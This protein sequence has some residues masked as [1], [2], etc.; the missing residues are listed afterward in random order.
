MK[1]LFENLIFFLALLCFFACKPSFSN[2]A[3]TAEKRSFASLYADAPPIMTGAAQMH[4]YIPFIK[5]KK[6]A[7]LANHTSLVGNTHLVDTL[8]ASGVSIQKIFSPEH[9]FRGNADNGESILNGKDEKT[10]IDIISLYGQKKKPDSKD[11]ENVEVLLFDIQDVG[12]RFY[13]Y[14]SSMHYMMEACSDFEIPFILLDRPNPNIHVVDG[15]VLSKGFESFVGIHPIPVAH[16]MTLGEL[17]KMI[18]GEEW[19]Q[20]ENSLQLTVIPCLNYSRNTTFFPDIPPSPN[21]RS[22]KA[23]AMYPSLCFFEGTIVSVGRGT[24]KPF[25][26]IGHPDYQYGNHTFVPIPSPGASAPKLQGQICKGVSMSN[27]SL[28]SIKQQGIN[29][30]W[31]ISFYNNLK[32]KKAF[33]LPNLFFDKLAGN[34]S[35]RIQ[36]EA[37]WSAEEIKKSWLKDLNNF[38]QQRKTYLIYQ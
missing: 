31:L 6:V 20:S 27:I 34:D 18:V 15:P 22:A 32:N 5:D 37:G 2:P 28:E 7:V 8:L 13:T 3:A 29:L 33:F 9:G 16:G 12:T 35:L 19:L 1:Q 25:E 26:Q 36:I 14:L 17:A 4:K 30:E 24:E 21:L 38:I 11:L 10:G 23:I